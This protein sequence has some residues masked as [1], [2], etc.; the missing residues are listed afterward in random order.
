MDLTSQFMGRWN[1]INYLLNHRPANAT[2]ADIQAAIWWFCRLRSPH[3]S[4]GE[5]DGDGDDDVVHR[6]VDDAR[7]H[8]GEF[9]PGA[10]QLAAILINSCVDPSSHCGSPL[11]LFF[12]YRIPPSA[13]LPLSSKPKAKPKSPHHKSKTKHSSHKSRHH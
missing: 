6:L 4:A 11:L 10:G 9:V 3:K 12:E 7:H 8:G 1:Y 5:W 13:C 2:P